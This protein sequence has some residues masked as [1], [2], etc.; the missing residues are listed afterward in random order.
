MRLGDQRGIALVAVLWVVAIMALV[1]AVFMRETR[2]EIALTRNLAEDAKAE[3]LAEA[4]VNRAILVLLG[5][6]DS[7]A[8]RADGTPFAFEYGGGIVQVSMQDEG[9]KIDLNR[10]GDAVLQGLFT[11]LGVNQDAAQ[12]LVDA[13]ADFRDADGLKHVNGAE[14][15]EYARAGLPYD[16]KDAP[17]AATEE[18]LQVFGMTPEIY[19]RVAPLV[20]VYS[21]RRDVNLATAPPAVL[22]ALPYLSPDRARS[23]LEQRAA[24]QGANR[25]FRVLAVTVLVEATTAEGGRVTREVVLRRSG[26]GARPFDIV[27]WRRVWPSDTAS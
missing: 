4:G 16:A 17:F 19:A 27:K 2:T 1:A 18:L 15:A 13:I 22:A 21:P 11:S 9:G 12:H 8:W 25:R 10:A 5:L 24:N 26:S 20:T 7:I 23:I 6:D 14:D 3:A